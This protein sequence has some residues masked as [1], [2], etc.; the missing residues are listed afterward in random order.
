MK[1]EFD[2]EQV[3][4]IH[5]ACVTEQAML[6]SNIRIAEGGLGDEA[7]INRCKYNSEQYN[8]IMQQLADVVKEE[9]K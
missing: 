5:Q 7:F 8:K 6:K 3:W 4:Y 1:F 2:L 9:Y